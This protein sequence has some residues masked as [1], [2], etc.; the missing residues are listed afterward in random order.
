LSRRRAINYSNSDSRVVAVTGGGSGIG[1]HTAKHFASLGCDVAICG[2]DSIKIESAAK[3][4]QE[5]FGG[6]VVGFVGDVS[7]PI[8]MMEF[9]DVTRNRLGG[10][11]VLVCNAAVLGPIG[12][13]KE[14]PFERV[15]EVFS[16]N[17]LGVINS[18]RAFMDDF[19]NAR[20]PRV[21]VLSG[22]GMG[23]PRPVKDAP[24]YVSTKAAI[25]TFVEVVAGDF[26]TLNGAIVV[27]APGSSIATNFLQEVLE[28]GEQVAGPGLYKD[29]L[30]HQ[31]NEVGKSLDNYFEL[32]DLVM[33]DSGL[34][35]NGRIL[36]AR[37]NRPEVLRNELAGK[38]N[39]NTYKLRRIDNDLFIAGEEGTLFP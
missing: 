26:E 23:G 27:V 38:V 33:G 7:D 13:W 16:I 28:V 37:W 8:Q 34:L 36:S 24:F 31:K 10:V 17:V 12:S 4:L 21:V 3:S 2:R 35:L 22:G 20:S 6:S 29:A 15:T 9:A 39:L 30:D 5:E 18:V 1:L 32:L 11:D 14:S 19:V 25:A